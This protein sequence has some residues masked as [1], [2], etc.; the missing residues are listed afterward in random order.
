ME[1]KEIKK[2]IWDSQLEAFR[3]LSKSLKEDTNSQ[4]IAR[5]EGLKIEK[6]W[7]S[8]MGWF[9]K[10]WLT[11]VIWVTVAVIIWKSINPPPKKGHHGVN[12]YGERY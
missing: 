7:G 3:L 1:K 11:A 10:F 12:K 6:P 4:K 5:E 2:S 8:T 9:E